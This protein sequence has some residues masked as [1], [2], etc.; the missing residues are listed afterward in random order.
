MI[1]NIPTDS[2]YKYLAVG[3]LTIAIFCFYVVIRNLTTVGE[4]LTDL[5]VADSQ[6][7]YRSG[8]DS[9]QVAFTDYRRFRYEAKLD[10]LAFE[11][12]AYGLLRQVQTSFDF[13]QRLAYVG[14]L[15]GLG[16]SIFGFSLWYRKVQKFDDLI[17][18]NNAHKQINDK[19]LKIHQV[20][21]EKEFSVYSELWASLVTLKYATMNLRPIFEFIDLNETDKDRNE[22]RLKAFQDAFKV[23]WDAY[24]KNKPFYPKEIFDLVDNAMSVAQKE[25]YQ[26]H[27]FGDKK[28]Y[29]QARENVDELVTQIEL[30]SNK[31]QE[32][33]GMVEI[34][35]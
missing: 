29:D 19:N 2:L 5:Y 26:F 31:I 1:P 27:F 35:V 12:K 6:L 32:R 8:L 15:I 3:G 20:Q 28:D 18:R 7:K 13:M 30:V 33:I 24:E 11:Q 17:I 23:S 22:K 10:S 34:V 16:I 4:N 21:F 9:G 25:L 14:I